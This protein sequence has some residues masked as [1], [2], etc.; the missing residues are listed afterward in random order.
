[1]NSVKLIAAKNINLFINIIYICVKRYLRLILFGLWFSDRPQ[2]GGSGLSTLARSF[3]LIKA[4]MIKFVDELIYIVLLHRRKM[5]KVCI[6]SCEIFADIKISCKSDVKQML[7]KKFLRSF[8]FSFWY[9]SLGV[10]WLVNTQPSQRLP[11]D[12]C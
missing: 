1:M 4:G 9:L 10:R 6:W 7:Q 8:F 2:L 3:C 12:H 5:Q 11:F